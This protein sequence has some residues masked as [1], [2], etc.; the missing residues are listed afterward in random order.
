MQK[1]K[2]KKSWRRSN[3]GRY[4]CNCFICEGKWRERFLER[5][6]ARGKF[7]KYNRAEQDKEL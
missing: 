3:L 2:R 4:G 7:F 5:T 6:R 1:K